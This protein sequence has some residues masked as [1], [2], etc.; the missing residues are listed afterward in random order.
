MYIGTRPYPSRRRARTPSLPMR[1]PPQIL[2]SNS[3]RIVGVPYC[4]YSRTRAPD[5][6]MTRSTFRE[7]RPRGSVSTTVPSGRVSRTQHGLAK[8][9]PTLSRT[10]VRSRRVRTGPVLCPCRA[11][12]RCHERGDHRGLPLT[13]RGT[14]ATAA[15]QS[16]DAM[17]NRCKE[18][19][20]A[21]GAIL[22]RL[23][24]RSAGCTKTHCLIGHCIHS[25]SARTFLELRS[26]ARCRLDGERWRIAKGEVPK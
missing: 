19:R 10:N 15:A 24:Q 11:G 22:G 14:E 2:L 26:C 16:P 9:M 23:A 3:T 4:P 18:V 20:R 1:P 6:R 17:H 13:Y 25:L 5:R 12:A 7:S 8:L 21:R